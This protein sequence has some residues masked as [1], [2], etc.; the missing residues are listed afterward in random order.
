[1]KSPGGT[2]CNICKFGHEVG[3]LALVSNFGHKV[4][5]LALVKILP[6]RWCHLHYFEIVSLEKHAILKNLQLASAINENSDAKCSYL[7]ANK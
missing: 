2:T 4:T 6:A 5:T 3:L 7:L 1:M